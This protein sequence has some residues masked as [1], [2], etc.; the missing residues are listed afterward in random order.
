[1]YNRSKQGLKNCCLGEYTVK[2]T[3][4]TGKWG[5]DFKECIGGPGR[6]AW[7]SYNKDGVPITK[8]TNTGKNG[9]KKPYE[10]NALINVYGGQR[11]GDV[12]RAPS[13]ISANFW[14]DVEDKEFISSESKVKV[15][16]PPKPPEPFREIKE[17]RGEPYFV[18]NCLDRAKEVRHRI[19]LLIQE[20]NTQE[21]FNRFKDSLGSSGDPDIAEKEGRAL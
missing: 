4:D 16:F 2:N 18:W 14:K 15:Y 5:G 7:D 10:L 9:L 8:V 13:F 19:I 1:M 3:G 6:F 11:G 20:W 12:H 17:S 21:E